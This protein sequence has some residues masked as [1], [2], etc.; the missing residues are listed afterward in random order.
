MLQA[1]HERYLPNAIV[2][3][4]EGGESQKSLGKLLPF[5][6]T[7]KPMDSKATA[8]VCVNYACQLPT[9]DLSKMLEL[10]LPVHPQDEPDGGKHQR[11]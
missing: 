8:Y 2:I 4:A 3:L 11:Q 5:L 9:S 10:L 7:I 6:Q 1:I